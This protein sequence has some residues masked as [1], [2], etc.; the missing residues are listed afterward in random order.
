MGLKENQ[1]FRTSGLVIVVMKYVRI[2]SVIAQGS[3]VS[4][5]EF[6]E[7]LE[8]DKVF[9]GLFFD[10]VPKAFNGDVMNMLLPLISMKDLQC[11]L[12]LKTWILVGLSCRL[13]SEHQVI[14]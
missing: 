11:G 4:H 7:L 13:M 3:V 2:L 5:S 1:C 14:A 6:L 12:H 9:A 10:V 8:K